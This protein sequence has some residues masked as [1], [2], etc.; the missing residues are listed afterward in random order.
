MYKSDGMYLPLLLPSRKVIGHFSAKSAFNLNEQEV[1]SLPFEQVSGPSKTF[2]AYRDVRELAVRKFFADA[3]KLEIDLP[4]QVVSKDGM[5]RTFTK[6]HC[7]PTGKRRK[8]QDWMDNPRFS[9]RSIEAMMRRKE[10]D[11]QRL[12]GSATTSST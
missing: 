8:R 4:G 2:Y 12:K 5:V 7:D 9:Y 3:C 11:K 1:L 10:E 6:M